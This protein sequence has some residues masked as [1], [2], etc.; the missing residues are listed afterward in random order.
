MMNLIVFP[1]A[2][3]AMTAVVLAFKNL[4]ASEIRLLTAF[5]PPMITGVVVYITAQPPYHDFAV[6]IFWL[7]LAPM[8]G[9][10]WMVGLAIVRSRPEGES[11]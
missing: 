5:I 6:P 11:E 7:G 9:I 3:L 2:L 10:G 4:A 8:V 1:L